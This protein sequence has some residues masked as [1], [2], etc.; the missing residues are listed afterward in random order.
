MA[1]TGAVERIKQMNELEF[2]I[3]RAQYYRR[4]LDEHLSVRRWQWFVYVGL[5]ETSAWVCDSENEKDHDSGRTC[6]SDLLKLVT[7][8][9]RGYK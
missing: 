6:Q 5:W 8:G 9:Q 3:E 2:R 1:G 4:C 7:P